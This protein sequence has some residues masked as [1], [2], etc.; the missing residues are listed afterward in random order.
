MEWENA[1]SC[2]GRRKRGDCERNSLVGS[3]SSVIISA[4]K[5]DSTHHSADK[6]LTWYTAV[7]M[8]SSYHALLCSSELWLLLIICS[9]SITKSC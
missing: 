4:T 6:R 7:I 3:R 5:I 2:L 8:F 1:E 9:I